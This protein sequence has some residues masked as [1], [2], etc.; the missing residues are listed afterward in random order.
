MAQI[1]WKKQDYMQLGRAVANFN[2]KRN[3]ILNEENKLYLPAEISYQDLKA[4]ILTR[5]ELNRQMNSLKR[6]MKKG[7]ESLYTTKSGEILTKWEKQELDIEKRIATKRLKKELAPYNIKDESGFTRA[8]MG[9][10]QARNLVAQIRNLRKIETAKGSE[11]SRLKSRLHNIGRAD[12]STKRGITYREN[13][14]EEMKKY[15]HFDNYEKLEKF[16]ET[17]KDPD[18]FFEKMSVNINVQDLTYQSDMYLSQQAFNGF[19]Q[20]LGI[21]IDEDTIS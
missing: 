21:E 14:I 5:A 7:A 1:I 17:Y 10:T 9:S 19:L 12:Y 2:R 15:S 20:D 3:K 6:F 16:F 8:E 11:F 18:T 13:Y 4:N